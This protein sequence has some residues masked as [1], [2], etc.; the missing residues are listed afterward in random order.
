MLLNVI[1]V[2]AEVVSV[3]KKTGRRGED[4]S[5]WLSLYGNT[6]AG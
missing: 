4:E 2:Y 1:G 6:A 5:T 3:Q